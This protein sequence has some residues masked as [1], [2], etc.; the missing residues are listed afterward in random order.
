LV[1]DQAAGGRK[2]VCSAGRRASAESQWI[3]CADAE[4]A[5]RQLAF[6]EIDLVVADSQSFRHSLQGWTDGATA[7][8]GRPAPLVVVL[9]DDEPRGIQQLL[10]AGAACCLPKRLPQRILEN[11]LRQLVAQT[12]RKVRVS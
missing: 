11:E 10:D 8:S 3:E 1:V 2:R 12:R 4:T 7:R 5:S 9:S 6:S